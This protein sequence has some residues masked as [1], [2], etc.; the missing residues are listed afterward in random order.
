M[1]GLTVIGNL[2]QRFRWRFFEAGKGRVVINVKFVI[3]VVRVVN[4]SVSLSY[5]LCKDLQ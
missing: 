1:F 3:F 4:D 2:G 5:N